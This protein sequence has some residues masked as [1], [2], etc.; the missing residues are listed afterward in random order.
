[1]A[2]A[3]SPSESLHSSRR[4]SAISTSTD[5]S[6]IVDEKDLVPAVVPTLGRRRTLPSPPDGKPIL[7]HGR[8]RSS[9]VTRQSEKHLPDIAENKILSRP[10]QKADVV[11]PPI[12]V[13]I[14]E[15]EQL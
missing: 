8:E 13:L 4:A 9:T 12:N 11:V 7:A 3:G 15:G 14:V 1:V 5:D 10:P 2:A 6:V